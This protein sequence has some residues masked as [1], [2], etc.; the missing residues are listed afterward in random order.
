MLHFFFHARGTRLQKTKE[1]MFRSLLNQLC[2]KSVAT[3]SIVTSFFRQKDVDFGKFGES[4]HWNASELERLFGDAITDAMKSDE[5]TLFVDAL[6]EAGLEIAPQLAE[7]F[8]ALESKLPI[9]E[10]KVKI[11]ISCRHYLHLRIVSLWRY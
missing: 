7:Y 9:E 6:D 2:R 3:Y 5:V 11:C 10:R 8:Q 1:G 4:W